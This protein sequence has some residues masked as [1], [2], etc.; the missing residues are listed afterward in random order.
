MAAQIAVSAQGID[1]LVGGSDAAAAR[2]RETLGALAA[3]GRSAR[4]IERGVG[5]I[6]T[7]AVQISMLAVSGAVEAARS[8]EAG[9]GFAHV[10]ADIKALAADAAANT[11]RIRDTIEDMQDRVADARQ[12]FDGLAASLAVEAQSRRQL[13]GGLARA[14]ADLDAVRAANADVRRGA[15]AIFAAVRDVS[16]GAREIGMAAEQ[17]SRAAS[18]A[19]AAARQQARGAEEL[20]A[21]IE[22]IAGLADSLRK[23]VL[24]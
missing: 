24:F 13:P 3:L 6:E 14:G 20:A 17:A 23:D 11:G 8:G 19:A 1:A 7:V 10:S 15:D 12:D 4:R 5:N 2:A 22:E 16:Q 21:A 9:R 18:E